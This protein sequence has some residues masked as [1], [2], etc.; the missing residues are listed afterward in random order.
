M[1]KVRREVRKENVF[2]LNKENVLTVIF[3]F[4]SFLK[5]PY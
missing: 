3:R 1:G 4:V 2:Q 5:P